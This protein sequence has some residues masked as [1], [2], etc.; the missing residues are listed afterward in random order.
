MKQPSSCYWSNYY[1]ATAAGLHPGAAAS[2]Q[3][4]S[5]YLHDVLMLCL[6]GAWELELRQFMPP[7]SLSASVSS[8]LERGLIECVEGPA[9]P[10]VV[11]APRPRHAGS[12]H[13]RRGLALAA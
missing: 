1:R 11:A 3:G 13:A 4:Q 2:L 12:Q 10:A 6:R 7:A 8:L 9:R 5:L